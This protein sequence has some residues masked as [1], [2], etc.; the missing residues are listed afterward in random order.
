MANTRKNAIVDRITVTVDPALKRL[1]DTQAT[2]RGMSRSE[3]VGEAVAEWVKR[4]VEEDVEVVE[5]FG[6]RFDLVNDL[7]R[8]QGSNTRGMLQKQRYVLEM[9]LELLLTVS[10]DASREELRSKAHAVIRAERDREQSRR[11]SRVDSG[12]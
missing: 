10:P 6:V 1:L 8:S 7:V 2:E 5:G 11:R 3:A 4:R 9:V 12:R